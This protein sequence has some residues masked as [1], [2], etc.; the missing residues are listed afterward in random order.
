V[1]R[2]ETE[3]VVDVALERT[4]RRALYGRALDLGTG[5][6]CIALSFARQRPTWC[7]VAV[8]SSER[9]LEVAA[10]NALRLGLGASTS[11]GVGDLFEALPEPRRAFDLVMANPPYIRSGELPGLSRDIVDFEPHLAL[12]GG[13]DGL[14]VLRRIVSEAPEHLAPGGVLVLEVGFGQAGALQE[15]MQERGFSSIEARKD[16]GGHERVVSG[17]Y[18]PP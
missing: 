6:G 9:A 11:L 15:L 1:P 3:T 14:A 7:V 10:E 17:T 8:D 13:A 16:Y 4:Q 12:D 18:G 2:P 5:S